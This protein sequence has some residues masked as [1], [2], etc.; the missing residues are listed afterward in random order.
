MIPVLTQMLKDFDNALSVVDTVWAWAA[1]TP[2]PKQSTTFGG[3]HAFTSVTVRDYVK[4]LRTD[5]KTDFRR[6]AA[7]KVVDYAQIRITVIFAFPFRKND[8]YE[9]WLLMNVR[10]DVDNLLK[11]LLDVL[12][13]IGD[14][15]DSRVVEVKARK[16]RFQLPVIALKFDS[17]VKK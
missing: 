16:I 17:V 13:D 11:P 1:V 9:D 2:K 6:E 10:P 7:R 5:L 12:A 15:Q 4:T 8:E 3:G 14:F